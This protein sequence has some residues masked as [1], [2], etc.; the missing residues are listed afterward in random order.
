MLEELIHRK[1]VFS[2]VRLWEENQRD[3]AELLKQ[4]SCVIAEISPFKT[5]KE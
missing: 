3:L 4:L 5:W 2:E 1:K